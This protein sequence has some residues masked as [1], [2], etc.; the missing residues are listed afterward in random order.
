MSGKP[1]S[2]RHLAVLDAI[3]DF[4]EGHG[5]APSM[6]DIM[7]KTE[8]TSLSVVSYYLRRLED[9]GFIRRSAHISRSIE[10]VDGRDI[11]KITPRR[12]NLRIYN[13]KADAGRQ[14]RG[15]GAFIPKKSKKDPGLQAR[16]EAVVQKALANEAFSQDHDII[17]DYRTRFSGYTLKAHKL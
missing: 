4:K 1:Y 8:I 9:E 13:K 6:R 10:I 15:E 12:V 17:H 7:R 2:T 5:Y 3:R 16:I 11:E 14:G